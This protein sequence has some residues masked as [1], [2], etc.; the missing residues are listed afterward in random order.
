M[1]RC[2]VRYGYKDL[3]K[4]DEDFEKVLF[5][6][7]LFFVRLESMMEGYSDSDEF[8]VPEQ[9]PGSGR[10]AFLGVGERTCATVCS[11][12]DLSFSSQDLVVPA[13]VQSPRAPTGLPLLQCSAS[14]RQG[15]S[16]GTVGD[17][18]GMMP[19]RR[20]ARSASTSSPSQEVVR[21]KR[22]SSRAATSMV[23]RSSSPA[24]GTSSIRQR[25]PEQ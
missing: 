18:L 10:A 13:A 11:N 1:F 14:A 2:V 8:S 7:I 17:E 23:C 15:T 22:T 4:R 12:G 24:S 6:C 16:G 19:S 9:T 5:D 21:R 20:R 3:H 25:R